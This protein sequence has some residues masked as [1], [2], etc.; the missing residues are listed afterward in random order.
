M[1]KLVRVVGWPLL[2]WN[3]HSYY[4]REGHTTPPCRVWA[5]RLQMIEILYHSADR[6]SDKCTTEDHSRRLLPDWSEKPIYFKLISERFSSCCFLLILQVH[7]V[8]F[9]P[10]FISSIYIV[11]RLTYSLLI[12][13]V[14]CPEHVAVRRVYLWWALDICAVKAGL[15]NFDIL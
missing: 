7:S 2:P 15:S 11:N 10:F 6:V 13:C 8:C 3:C 14:E 4:D 9:F 1:D 5:V 12:Y